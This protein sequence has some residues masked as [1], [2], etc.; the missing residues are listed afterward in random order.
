[1][2]LPSL[3]SVCPFGDARLDSER[4]ERV[5][6]ASLSVSCVTDCCRVMICLVRLAHLQKIVGFSGSRVSKF[7]SASNVSITTTALFSRSSAHQASDEDSD[8]RR[9][10]LRPAW[11]RLPTPAVLPRTTPSGPPLRLHVETPLTSPWPL[12]STFS[13]SSPLPS[14]SSLYRYDYGV[15]SDSNLVW[16]ACH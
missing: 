11:M 1:M 3:V 14:S 16:L 10:A 5:S 2:Y 4:L 7:H 6:L 8:M 15:S 9:A 13:P 12:S